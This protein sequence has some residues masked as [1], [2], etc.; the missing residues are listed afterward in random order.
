MPSRKSR[1]ARDGDGASVSKAVAVLRAF[2][3]GQQA[4]GVRELANALGQPGSSVHRLLQILRKDGLVEWDPG[5]QKYRSGM[6]LFR[7]SAILSRRFKL[8]DVARPVM[9]DLAAT[10]GESCWLGIYEPIQNAHAY[11]FEVLANRPLNYAAR[12]AQ[13]ER[14]EKS[15]A[16]AAIMAFLPDAD[17]LKVAAGDKRARRSASTN[18]IDAELRRIRIDGYAM[19]Q[20]SDEDAP[21]TIAAPVFGAR[22]IPAASLTL[23]VPPHRCPSGKVREL[24]AAV[25]RAAGRLSYRIGS[26]LVGAAGAGAW[27]QGLNAIAGLLQRDVADITANVATRGGDGALRQ[28]Q[29]GQGA[30]CFAVAD[31]LARAFR[32]KPPFQRP[33][34]RLRAMFSIFPLYLHI[35]VKRGAPIKTFADLKRGRISAGD[36]DFTTARAVA[37]LLQIAGL[38]STPVAAERRLVFL[39]YLEAHREFLDDKLEAVISLTALDDPSYRELARRSDIRLLPLQRRLI[40]AFAAEHPTYEAAAIPSSTYPGCEAVTHT[41]MAPTVMVTTIDRSDDEVYEVTRTIY[42]N[43][44]ELAAAVSGFKA[45]G[46]DFIF[47]GVTIPLHPAARRFWREQGL[48][49]SRDVS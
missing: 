4:W 21:V 16:G 38:A 1:T 6:E 42:E 47:R 39:D 25:A 36:R 48:I 45:F 41:I 20:S 9:I 24:G 12:L 15:A 7:W 31:S 8:A 23:A 49:Y 28:L 33:H 46:S 5:N 18:I 13:Y 40:E 11:V 30:Y 44:K 2:V 37:R 22:D 32:G 29:A 26:Q 34:D 17:R 10:V 35:A 3:D 14:L 19:R 43:R 27:H